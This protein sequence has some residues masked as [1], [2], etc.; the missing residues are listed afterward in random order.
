MNEN[1]SKFERALNTLLDIGFDIECVNGKYVHRYNIHEEVLSEREIIKWANAYLSRNN[2]V[3][4]NTKEFRH[5]NN[6]AQ[7][8]QDIHNENFDSFFQKELRRDENIW[9]WD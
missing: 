7:T 3:R 4:K 9:N 2:P 1:F 8:R 5:R 6:R